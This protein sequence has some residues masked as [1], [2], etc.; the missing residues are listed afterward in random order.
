MTYVATIFDKYFKTQS[1]NFWFIGY[2][3]FIAKPAQ[4]K[5]VTNTCWWRIFGL[6]VAKQMSAPWWRDNFPENLRVL[7]LFFDWIGKLGILTSA[8]ANAIVLPW[9]NSRA[10]SPIYLLI[11]SWLH[12]RYSRSREIFDAHT[13]WK[14]KY[15]EKRLA[16]ALLFLTRRKGA[17]PLKNMV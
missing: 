10:L 2:N 5:R 15:N 14:G 16:Y 12:N 11:M 13:V 9:M 1:Y 4:A 7:A 8:S 3:Y 17:C 6:E